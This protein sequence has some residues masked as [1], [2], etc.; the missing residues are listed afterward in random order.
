MSLAWR[1][2]RRS[3]RA[4]P[5]ALA[6]KEA[7]RLGR[8]AARPNHSVP[9]ISTL[10]LPPMSSLRARQLK[11]LVRGTAESRQA[12]ASTLVGAT[13]SFSSRFPKPLRGRVRRAATTLH[14][15][16]TI[17]VQTA[18]G[19][20]PLE[21]NEVRLLAPFADE[22]LELALLARYLQPGMTAIDVGAN[23]GSYSLMF[24]ARVGE[25]GSVLAVEPDPRMLARLE[26]VRTLNHLDGVLRIVA[27]AVAADS[28]ERILSLSAEP[29]LNHL[30]PTTG[31]TS[32]GPTTPVRAVSYVDL[33]AQHSMD[34]VH[35]LKVDVEGAEP[36][37]LASVMACDDEELH[38]ALIMFEYEPTHW[39]RLG[40]SSF[41]PTAAALSS[42]YDLFAIDYAS[43][44]LLPIGETDQ[45]AWSGRNVMAVHKSNVRDALHRITLGASTLGR[46]EPSGSQVGVH[47]S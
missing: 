37:V 3:I 40:H 16:H 18:W 12:Y 34:G 31:S 32:N 10:P 35:L 13:S 47:D 15:P 30:E 33:L 6:G 26:S 46:V 25:S 41:A 21:A 14:R 43:G 24:S 36:E 1:A 29:A 38:P 9:P 7:V 44:Q 5:T 19:L 2:L 28:G 8:E 17:N 23:R 22:P 20:L 42:Q 11:P 27:A 4:H 39:E 45:P